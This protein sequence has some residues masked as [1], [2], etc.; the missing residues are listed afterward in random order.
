MTATDRAELE[1]VV[2]VEDMEGRGTEATGEEEGTT[3][4][5]VTGMGGGLRLRGDWIMGM[6]V[7]VEGEEEGAGVGVGM[8][9]M[10]D[11]V[12]TGEGGVDMAEEEVGGVEER[13]VEMHFSSRE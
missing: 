7:V 6:V 1:E 12:G 4:G 10:G 11:G 5:E 8:E 9:V 2:E 3:T 13:E